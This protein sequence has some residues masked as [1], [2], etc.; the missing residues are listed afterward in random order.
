MFWV[1]PARLTLRSIW[2][3]VHVHLGEQSVLKP[4]DSYSEEPYWSIQLF[5]LCVFVSGA[6]SHIC[7]RCRVITV[8][9]CLAIVHSDLF[10]SVCFTLLNGY[11]PPHSPPTSREHIC[12]ERINQPGRESEAWNPLIY[13]W[14]HTYVIFSVSKMLHFTRLLCCFEIFSYR[15]LFVIKV[16][17]ISAFIVLKSWEDGSLTKEKCCVLAGCVVNNIFRIS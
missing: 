15:L 17:S 13:V 12:W 3:D 9:C 5:S 11:I 8:C 1:Y 2:T 4:S 10:C 7:S 14:E 16:K 6:R